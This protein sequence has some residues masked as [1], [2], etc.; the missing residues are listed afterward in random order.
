MTDLHAYCREVEQVLPGAW[1]CPSCKFELNRC[2]MRAIDGAVGVNPAQETIPCPNGC[3]LPLEP[4]TYRKAFADMVAI[5]EQKTLAIAGA[6]SRAEKAEAERDAL[7]AKL[8]ETERLLM[9]AQTKG[10]GLELALRRA[11]GLL[12]CWNYKAGKPLRACTSANLCPSCLVA[13]DI[14]AALAGREVPR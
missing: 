6:V 14:E 13:N 4:V 9:L 11:S 1:W 8:G 12:D 5:A 7:A 2:V 10:A 3:A